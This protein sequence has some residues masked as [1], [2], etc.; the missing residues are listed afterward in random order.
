MHYPSLKAVKIWADRIGNCP[1]FFSSLANISCVCGFFITDTTRLC[2]TKGFVDHIF[3][4]SKKE[5][6][7]QKWIQSSTTPD[8]GYQWKSD[9]VT[10]RHHKAYHRTSFLK[11]TSLLDA[12]AFGCYSVLIT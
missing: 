3:H 9:N 10:I 11:H 1:R 5:G 4:K 6:R 7:V 12:L 8:P 2:A